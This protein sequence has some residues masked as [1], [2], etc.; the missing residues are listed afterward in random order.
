MSVLAAVV[1]VAFTVSAHPIAYTNW[2][3]EA[4]QGFTMA[5]LN[6]LTSGGTWSTNRPDSG[7]RNLVLSAGGEAPVGLLWDNPNIVGYHDLTLNAPADFSST[8]VTVNFQTAWSRTGNHKEL[9]VQGFADNDEEVFL[10][11]WHLAH[12]N[13]HLGKTQ[14]ENDLVTSNFPTG[15]HSLWWA[16]DYNVDRM[17]DVSVTLTPGKVDFVLLGESVEYT[18][19]SGTENLERLRFRLANTGTPRGYWLGEI[20]VIPEPNTALLLGFFAAIAVIHRKMRLS[21]K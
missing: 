8:P 3:T 18:F 1:G 13:L 19:E 16:N 14:Q 15:N 4:V 11:Q 20:E 12:D 21:E 10:A 6:E 5:D 9:F 17:L 2:G 7:V